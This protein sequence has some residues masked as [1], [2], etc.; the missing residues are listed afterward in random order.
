M[1][2]RDVINKNFCQYVDGYEQSGRVLLKKNHILRVAKNCEDIAR[3][4]GLSQELIDLAY[5]IG[6]AHDIG[7]FEQV[8]L[9]DTFSD[10]ASKMNH[11]EKSNEV[12]FEDGL[13][14]KFIDTDKYDHIIKTAVYNHNK[15]EIEAGLSEDELL[16]AKIIRDADKLDIL[17]VIT[18]EDM[19][20]I[21]WLPIFTGKQINKKFI[22]YFYARKFFNYKEIKNNLDQIITFY[23]FIYDLNFNESYHKIL[24]GN[25]YSLFNE[26]LK[27]VYDSKMV[28]EQL[29]NLLNSTIKYLKGQIN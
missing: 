12:L 14:R 9:Y 22:T 8:R 26:R 21:F 2:E 29:D 10:H 15:N 11:A 23:N 28:H 27:G 19:K 16:F 17:Y 18:F 3:S 4:L 13:I 7:R 24:E 5:V 25:Y 1:L 6:I 20:D